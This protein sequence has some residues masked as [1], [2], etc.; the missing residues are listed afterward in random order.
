MI[1]CQGHVILAKVIAIVFKN[2]F[3][4]FFSCIIFYP[5]PHRYGDTSYLITL[6]Q[7]PGSNFHGVTI[8][9]KVIGYVNLGY[10]LHLPPYM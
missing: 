2:V 4:S 5:A 10:L 7:L 3:F 9:F 8:I 6:F 1:G